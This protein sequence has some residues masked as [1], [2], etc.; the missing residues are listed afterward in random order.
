MQIKAV[1]SRKDGSYRMPFVMGGEKGAD[2]F[3]PNIRYRGS[4]QNDLIDTGKEVILVDTGLPAGTT[5]SRSR[6]CQ[7]TGNVPAASRARTSSRRHKV[8]TV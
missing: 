3:D 8:V 2:Q 1:R 6:I 4:L 5:R 7:T